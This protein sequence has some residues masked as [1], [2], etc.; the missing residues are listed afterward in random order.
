MKGEWCYWNRYFSKEKCELILKDGLKITPK[1]AALGVSGMSETSDNTVRRSKTRFILKSDTHFEWL[2][3]DLWK[4]AMRCNHDFFSFHVTNLS[5]IQ[6]AEYDES[7]QGEYK[8]HQDVFWIN[9]DQYHRKLTCVV[10]L[11]DPSEYEGGDFQMYGLTNPPAPEQLMEMKNLG[12]A[13]LIP[14]FINHAA[15]PVTKGCRYSLA[16][17]FEGPKWV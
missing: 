10:Q 6:L 2:F 5:Y 4:L 3:D 1:D 17:W 16:I 15:L 8:M 13:I 14:S 11:T 9:N 12:S 7:Y